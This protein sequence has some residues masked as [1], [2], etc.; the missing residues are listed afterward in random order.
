MILNTVW[1]CTTSAYLTCWIAIEL[2]LLIFLPII[3]LG[4]RGRGPMVTLKYIIIQSLSGLLILLGLLI[5]I[6]R[7]GREVIKSI[8][9]IVFI[10]KIGGFPFMHWALIIGAVVDWVSL[11][12]I[13]TI[14]KVLPLLIISNLVYHNL[15]P[16]C[17]L[18]W[19]IL[20]L[21]ATKSLK[22]KIVIIISS[23]FNLIAILSTFSIRR[24]K[25]LRL[26]I[27]YLIS[28]IPIILFRGI[29]N[30]KNGAAKSINRK[31]SS[32]LG[33]LIL[34]RMMGVPPLPG[35][36][37]K[38][39]VLAL[40]IIEGNYFLGTALVTGVGGMLA[41]YLGLAVKNLVTYPR[42]SM[43]SPSVVAP[44]VAILRFS[45]RVLMVV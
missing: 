16:L 33:V 1:G 31:L 17:V 21:L 40:I 15:Q 2:N 42:I 6:H 24:H 18:R 25:W 3:A 36:F 29:V 38:V 10:L 34:L 27:L 37:F 7:S 11:T 41:A 23:T 22:L 5:S 20:P 32:G 35:F 4:A 43:K 14:Q 45:L 44:A 8:I 28:T 9:S 39:E 26:L 19:L 13:L 30:L 12:I